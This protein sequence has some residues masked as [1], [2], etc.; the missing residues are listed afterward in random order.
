MQKI[1]LFILYILMIVLTKKVLFGG[2]KN[3]MGKK[4]RKNKS[5]QKKEK[6]TNNSTLIKKCNKILVDN[7]NKCKCDNKTGY[8]SNNG[9]CNNNN[10]NNCEDYNKCRKL[11]KSYQRKG[12][13]NPN[14]PKWDPNY[15]SNRYVKDSHNCYTYFLDDQIEEIKKECRSKCL[16][17]KS[18]AKCPKGEK[19]NND[20]I[21]DCGD[22]RPQP[23]DW[24]YYHNKIGEDEFKKISNRYTCEDM[25]YKV[26]QDNKDGSDN[27]I[28]PINFDT[29]CPNKHYKGAIVVD[30]GKKPEGHTF[31]FYRQ[32]SNG[33]F[34][35][36][37]G[38]LE[39]ENLDASGKAI[40]APHLADRNYN[41]SKKK[42][43]INYKN[44]CGYYCLPNN[45]HKDTNAK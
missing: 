10:N 8:P 3:K 5:K 17:K 21:E 4:K 40:W 31:H 16:Q 20:R 29:P 15:W 12:N 33:R 34:S 45:G 41:K 19:Y 36:K 43:G 7:E 32:D 26:N 2:K 13:I 25:V 22:L 37:P 42:D 44:F 28:T 14:E 35:H 30:P 39:I 1:Y 23:G 9:N 27:L 24:S 11:F 38:I 6:F 18:K